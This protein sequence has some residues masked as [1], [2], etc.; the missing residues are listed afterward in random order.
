ML[1]VNKPK[2]IK[3]DRP[4]Y[5]LHENSRNYKPNTHLYTERV[6]TF[7]KIY[8]ATNTDYKY[9]MTLN[10]KGSQFGL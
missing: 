1:I 10:E 8:M 6:G 7:D 3:S 4:T 5:I 2:I 9:L